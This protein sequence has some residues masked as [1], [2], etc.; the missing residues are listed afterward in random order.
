MAQTIGFARVS[1]QEAWAI[2]SEQIAEMVDIASTQSFH[3]GD[4]V[5]QCA[6]TLVNDVFWHAYQ[7]GR[8]DERAK[9][10]PDAGREVVDLLAH[11]R[12][13]QER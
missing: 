12:E 1:E 6:A 11:H 8:Y 10:Q 3:R 2:V 5:S 4:L 13:E 7:L 9:Q